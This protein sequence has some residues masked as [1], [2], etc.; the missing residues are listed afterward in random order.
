MQDKQIKQLAN[1]INL[2]M[3]QVGR[4]SEMLYK[5]DTKMFIINNTLQHLMWNI[6]VLHYESNVLHYFQS[7][8]YRVHTS[9]YALWGDIE[10]L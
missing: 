7:R 2:T 6:D 9:L 4:H 1:Y 10:S 8:I 3:H 5:M